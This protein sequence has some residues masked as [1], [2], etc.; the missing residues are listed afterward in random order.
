MPVIEITSETEFNELLND[1]TG[2][3][4]LFVDFY[5]QWC[6]PC[7][8]IAPQIHKFS[9]TYSHVTFL[10]VDVDVCQSLSEKYN[11]RSMPT[12]LIFKVGISKPGE[13]IVGADAKKIENALKLLTRDLPISN[14]F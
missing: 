7:K 1:T 11:V 13:P 4:Y 14:T 9:E 12:F 2:N 5:A 6:G 8:R 3:K 10:K